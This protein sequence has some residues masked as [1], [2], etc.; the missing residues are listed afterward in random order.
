MTAPAQAVKSRMRA[1]DSSACGRGGGPCHP[2]R[3]KAAIRDAQR[4]P[5]GRVWNVRFR[6]RSP[7]EPTTHCGRSVRVRTSVD[8]NTR[9]RGLAVMQR[10]IGFPVRLATALAAT[11]LSSC[12]P[13]WT[14]ET[15]STSSPSFPTRFR[16]DWY[17]APGPCHRDPD[18]GRPNRLALHIGATSLDYFDEFEGRLTHIIRQS[19]RSVQYTA[20]YSAEGGY[21]NASETLRLSQEGNEMTLEPER[22]S[23]RYYRCGSH[24]GE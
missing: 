18:F 2:G 11:F 6:R 9:R 16:G 13:A 17:N 12:M 7:V 4:L 10:S 3:R 1:R 22:T 15:L 14:A 23:S 8:E 20:E 5:L 19:D 21:W 24:R